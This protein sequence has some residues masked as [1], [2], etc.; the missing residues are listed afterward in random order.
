MGRRLF[1]SHQIVT[2]GTFRQAIM[3]GEGVGS[4]VTEDRLHPFLHH[5]FQNDICT[6]DA[7]GTLLFLK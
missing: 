1:V 6:D 5:G 4:G 7:H 2:D 3:K